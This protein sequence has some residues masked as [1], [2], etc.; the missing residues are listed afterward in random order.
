MTLGST[1]PLVR[2]H[3]PQGNAP[4]FRVA[5]AVHVRDQVG[6]ETTTAECANEAT[7]VGIGAELAACFVTVEPYQA[8][9]PLASG[10]SLMEFYA[11]TTFEVMSR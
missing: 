3:L 8:G 9:T 1:A 11:S 7:D 2:A 6:A 5:L 10:I 4:S